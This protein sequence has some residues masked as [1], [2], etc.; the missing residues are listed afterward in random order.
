MLLF[1]NKALFLES[2]IHIF[3]GN[4]LVNFSLV[5]VTIKYGNAHR[6]QR[7]AGKFSSTNGFSFDWSSSSLEAETKTLSSLGYERMRDFLDDWDESISEIYMGNLD[8]A[9]VYLGRGECEMRRECP[10]LLSEQSISSTSCNSR[11]SLFLLNEWI[12]IQTGRA[13]AFGL[14]LVHA[15]LQALCLSVRYASHFFLQIFLSVACKRFL[16]VFFP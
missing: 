9:M 8:G 13:W 16:S 11:S 4:Q 6:Q 15:W 10:M 1:V 14:C 5:W 2:L 7:A 12:P 3:N